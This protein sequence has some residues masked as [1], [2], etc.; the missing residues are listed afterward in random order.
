MSITGMKLWIYF[1]TWFIRYFVIY[2]IV[3][4]I[5]T[6]IV[7]SS[8]PYIPFHVALITYLLFDIVLI[9]QSFFIQ[10]FVTRSKIGIILA[11]VFFVVQY[12]INFAVSS[13]PNV[14]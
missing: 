8:F 13:N 14:T 5:N 10:I 6:L 7:C 9:V 12:A 1:T 11:L 4:L 2:L 3:H